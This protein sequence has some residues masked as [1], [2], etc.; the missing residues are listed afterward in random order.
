MFS[1]IKSTINGF[2]SDR[3]K[4]LMPHLS[5]HAVGLVLAVVAF[6]WNIVS[7]WSTAA[8]MYL[9]FVLLSLE[10]SMRQRKQSLQVTL[11]AIPL[12]IAILDCTGAIIAMN[13]SWSKL[14]RCLNIDENKHNIGTNFTEL[15]LHVVS[16]GNIMAPHQRTCVFGLQRLLDG[17]TEQFEIDIPASYKGQNAWFSLRAVSFDDG[18]FRRVTVI[19]E[20][21]TQSKQLQS[22]LR[23]ARDASDASS[24]TKTEFVGR[25]CHEIRTPMSAL[26]SYAELLADELDRPEHVQAVS[27]VKQSGDYVLD[28]VDDILDLAKIEANQLDVSSQYCCPSSI[29]WDVV[30]LLQVKAKAKSLELDI[31]FDGPV[32]EFI[33]TDPKRLKQI[34]MNLIANAI[35]YTHSGG[36]RIITRLLHPQSDHPQIQFDVVDTGIGIDDCE[37]PQLFMPYEQLSNR[38]HDITGSGLGLPIT[39]QLCDLLGGE[40]MVRSEL[41]KGSTFS[42]ILPTDTLDGVRMLESPEQISNADKP[43]SLKRKSTTETSY[44]PMGT[45]NCRVLLVEDC[46]DTRRLLA[47]LLRMA[48][49]QVTVAHDGQTAIEESATA[50]ASGCGFDLILM[51]MHLPFV[52]G[53]EAVQILRADGYTGAIVALTAN[54]MRGQR[55]RCLAAGC[56][57]FLLKPI[58]QK[59]IVELVGQYRQQDELSHV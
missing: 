10:H 1:R 22:D 3:R 33:Q 43:F 37:S 34:L 32:P 40:I 49:A 28:L 42:V 20:D 35:K 25:V 12:Q 31:E 48:G 2:E 4:Q 39:K 8:V 58:A 6:H 7:A 26:V 50:I 14:L 29:L 11:D 57:D 5:M 51:D 44:R 16:D 15:L 21:V 59:Q 55:E 18:Q 46:G 13:R 30:Q 56:T 41:N 54:A 24:R 23:A 36:V 38:P 17:E 52:D 27:T 9:S 19:L 53:Y 47:F 45:V